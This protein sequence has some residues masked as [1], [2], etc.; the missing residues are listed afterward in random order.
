MISIK[1]FTIGNFVEITIKPLGAHRLMALGFI[2][3]HT[4]THTHTADGGDSKER[5]GTWPVSSGPVLQRREQR[6]EHGTSST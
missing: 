5:E 4:H 6:L 2:N 3:T 1:S